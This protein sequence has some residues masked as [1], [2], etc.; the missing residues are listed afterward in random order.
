MRTSARIA[1]LCLLLLF[2]A[3]SHAQ[4]AGSLWTHL[5]EGDKHV[6]AG[7]FAEAHQSYMSALHLSRLIDSTYHEGRALLG[8]AKLHD[9][10]DYPGA[11]RA[12]VAELYRQGIAS[13]VSYRSNFEAMEAALLLAAHERAHE[14][15]PDQLLVNDLTLAVAISGPAWTMNHLIRG[16]FTLPPEFHDVQNEWMLARLALDAGSTASGADRAIAAIEAMEK[17]KLALAGV[18]ARLWLCKEL[19]KPAHAKIGATRVPDIA[20]PA[21]DTAAARAW[22]F[23]GFE[24]CV[25][26][27][28][29]N[30]DDAKALAAARETVRLAGHSWYRSSTTC[31]DALA[32][33]ARLAPATERT[34]W[35]GE[36]ARALNTIAANCRLRLLDALGHGGTQWAPAD[37]LEFLRRHAATYPALRERMQHIERLA[38]RVDNATPVPTEAQRAQFRKRFEAAAK[39]PNSLAAASIMAELAGRDEVVDLLLNNLESDKPLLECAQAL[40]SL[41]RVEHL[42]RLLKL[43]LS[44]DANVAASAAACV[45]RLVKEGARP[46]LKAVLASESL[47]A[48]AR[49]WLL[50]ALALSGD[51]SGVAG[52]RK[53]AALPEGDAGAAMALFVLASLGDV[54][55]GAELFRRL[56]FDKHPDFYG[57]NLARACT[58]HVAGMLYNLKHNNR[59]GARAKWMHRESRSQAEAG[60]GEHLLYLAARDRRESNHLTQ[61]APLEKLRDIARGPWRELYQWAI[62]RAIKE[63]PETHADHDRGAAA[64]TPPESLG[65]SELD[66][67]ESELRPSADG[68]WLRWKSG[69]TDCHLSL[70]KRLTDCALEDNSIT[71]TISDLRRRVRYSQSDDEVRSLAAAL[72]QLYES[73][74]LQIPDHDPIP[75]TIAFKGYSWRDEEEATRGRNVPGKITSLVNPERWQNPEYDGNVKF[76]AALPEPDK[77]MGIV[78]PLEELSKA[79]LVVKVKLF[80]QSG[81]LRFRLTPLQESMAELPDLAV[82]SFTMEPSGA[83]PDQMVVVEVGATNLG[84]TVTKAGSCTLRFYVKN[85][86]YGEGFRVV[87][88]QRFEAVGWRHGERKWFKLLPVIGREHFLNRYS[89]TYVPEAGD[90]E[91]LVMLDPFDQCKE[92]DKENNKSGRLLDWALEGDEAAK[93]A[94]ADLMAAL[95]PVL[96]RLRAATD[97]DQALAV[98]NEFEAL[99]ERCKVKTESTRAARDMCR[100]IGH[101]VMCDLEVAAIQAELAEGVKDESL[102]PSRL[103]LLAGRLSRLQGD[104]IDSGLP[105]AT[106]QL[107]AARRMTM[108]LAKSSKLTNEGADIARALG[109]SDESVFP[110]G[111]KKMASTLEKI[112]KLLVLARWVDDLRRNTEAGH[113]V[114]KPSVKDAA[115]AALGLTGLDKLLGVPKA[116]FANILDYDDRTW[117]GSTSCLEAINLRMDGKITDA[118]LNARISGLEREFA[119]AQLGENILKDLGMDKLKEVRLLGTIVSFVSTWFKEDERYKRN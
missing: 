15:E 48:I 93:L 9:R 84:R 117:T 108:T 115:D 10:T 58:D 12:M 24:L 76:T 1:A 28:R 4:D 46:D 95:E 94:E 109:H 88:E 63:Y 110:E 33:L 97:R 61:L 65:G 72:D 103:R 100:R 45:M 53:M 6:S 56:P 107:D 106:T 7:K 14:R 51:E 3:L 74:E 49:A 22:R 57:N 34:A 89:H 96:Q 50:G 105:V 79:V 25:L 17:A 66:H 5:N 35:Q 55:A 101:G 42:P 98:C 40:E 116:Y 31:A 36:F 85:P 23:A 67:P 111:A 2:G 59:P 47:G 119:P 113:I 26:M 86:Q 64:A 29:T 99:F 69:S 73:A 104:L 114:V 44:P 102:T 78:I 41:A 13:L 39:D 21:I 83:K 60:S 75:M 38:S 87:A 54:V 77:E 70:H 8:L 90:V 27:A 118:E 82:N 92:S 91:F 80:G 62:D 43:A 18:E 112:D 32:V 52:L 71:L 37:L 11:Q 81:V 20:G 16:K 19:V 30:R 68:V